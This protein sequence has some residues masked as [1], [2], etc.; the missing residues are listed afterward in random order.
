MKPFEDGWLG[1][2]FRI[3]LFSAL[4]ESRFCFVR[5]VRLPFSPTLP[6]RQYGYQ[7]E[8]GGE[9]NALVEGVGGDT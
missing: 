8:E 1:V 2:G 5:D 6:K 9:D 7:R 4:S 3:A